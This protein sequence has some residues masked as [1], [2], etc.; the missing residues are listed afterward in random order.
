MGFLFF[1]SSRRRHTMCALVTGVQTCALPI[2]LACPPRVA[3]ERVMTDNGST[4][5]SRLFA[6]ALR[7]IGP[8][9]PNP[10]DTP[11]TNGNAE[12][13]IQTSLREWAYARLYASSDQRA[14]AIRPWIDDYRSEEHT[15]EL[16]SLMSNSYA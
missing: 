3:V 13:F 1:F 12:R 10:T 7:Q 9:T 8:A 15:S 14:P 6:D 11:R 2:C 4:Y 5:R 16:Q